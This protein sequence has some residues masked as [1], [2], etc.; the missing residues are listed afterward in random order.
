MAQLLVKRGEA[1][2][3]DF[4]TFVGY[5]GWAPNKLE[6][7]LQRGNWFMVA[8]DDQSL[9]DLVFARRNN[10]Q[11]DGEQASTG[12]DT[13]TTLMHRIGK[14][15]LVQE[16]ATKQNFENA[17]LNQWVQDRRNFLKA[18]QEGHTEDNVD[19]SELMRKK[20]GLIIQPPHSSSQKDAS[21]SPHPIVQEGTIYRA[22]HPIVLKEQ[23]FHE[24]LVLILKTDE[25]GNMG[26]ILNRPSSRIID[27]GGKAQKVSDKGSSSVVP[28]RYG[29]RYGLYDEK[30]GSDEQ[31][32]KQTAANHP[33]AP[34]T[35]L[36]FGHVGLREAQVGVP[37]APEDD[38]YIWQCSRQ[39]AE[40]A[41]EMGLASPSDF[42]VT[43]GFTLWERKAQSYASQQS[44]PL[45]MT[46]LEKEF[47]PVAKAS[48]PNLWKE[49]LQQ[50]CLSMET[51]DRNLEK[52][53]AAYKMAKI[54]PP[55]RAP[56]PKHEKESTSNYLKE[57]SQRQ[58]NKNSTV[59]T[60]TST[61]DLADE[62]LR[63]WMVMF[64]LNTTEADR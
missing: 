62:A 1:T 32:S 18:G 56:T 11:P 51:L 34:E 48:I 57:A 43:L 60:A 16:Y 9:S 33:P 35:W 40:T 12:M 31:R 46:R 52:G 54:L 36:H 26:V 19:E 39:D 10:S 38:T 2:P 58:K 29:G 30:T 21:S 63:R 25:R 55:Q 24:S 15:D 28:V 17:V 14:A 41:V 53:K 59:G 45:T 5:A 42:L 44:R 23:F 37:I 8:T 61:Y 22:M 27:L 13:W 3:Q 6:S 50:T 4:V 49:L 7:E 64:L 47:Q 20:N